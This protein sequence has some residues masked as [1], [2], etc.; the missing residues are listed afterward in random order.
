MIWNDE[1]HEAFDFE[2]SGVKEEYALQPWRRAQGLAWATSFASVRRAQG[3][4]ILR[5]DINPTR[6]LMASVLEDAIKEKRRLVGW[7]VIFDI[8]WLLAYDLEELVVKSKFLDGMLLWR[9]AQVEPEYEMTAHSKKSFGLK[10]CVEELWPDR[11]GYADEIDFHDDSPEARE[12]LHNYNIRDCVFT[13]KAAKYWWERLTNQQQSAALIEAESFPLVAR[14]NLHGLPV[15]TLVCRELQARLVRDAAA[16]IQL[17]APLGVTKE[18]ARSPIQLGNLLFDIWGLPCVKENVSKQTGKISRSTDKEV[19]FELANGYQGLPPDPRIKCLH[20]YR[21]ALNN[22]TKFADALINSAEYNGDDRTHPQARVFGTYSARMTY[23]SGQDGRGPGKREGTEKNVT[24]PVGFALHQE[25]R[26]KA[27]RLILVPP[28]GYTLVE[29]DAA[30]QEFKWMAVASRDETMLQLCK[31]GEDAHSFMGAGIEGL[32]YCETMARNK[33][34]DEAISGPQGIRMFGKVVNLS[35][36]YRTSARTLR[37]VARVDYNLKM[38]QQKADYVRNVYLQ[39]YARVPVYWNYQIDLTKRNHYVET[40]AGRRV[41]VDGDWTGSNGW[42]MASTAINYRIQ[43]TG[44]DQKYLALAVL[45]S[46]IPKVGAYF[47][48][49]LHDGLYFFVP[50]ARVAEFA[51]EG[52]KLLDS[53][54]YQRAWNFT[55]SIPMN[56]DCKT[57]PSWGLLR[58]WK[59]E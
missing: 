26:D 57:G 34:G 56:W 6:D 52:K 16:R 46:Y 29:F 28:S 45:R 49:D 18:I 38:D 5:G 35:C 27:F 32:D 40:L 1:A 31:P 4:T 25:K 19:L 41:K 2:T 42:S 47:A 36:Q 55:P 14:T 39:S 20:E 54:P 59:N 51:T 50:D 43:G 30:G 24:L 23:R 8:A 9:H 53:L 22:K 37:K 21:E 7:F 10:T 48:W 58:E 3:K 17:L 13:L 33:A 11:A 44:A 12:R 15:D